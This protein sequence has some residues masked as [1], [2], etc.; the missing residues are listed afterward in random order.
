VIKL[1]RKHAWLAGLVVGTLVTV[2]GSPVCRAERMDLFTALR[3]GVIWAEFRGNGAASVLATIGRQPGGPTEV[4][5]PAGTIFKVAALDDNAWRQWGD[6][7]YGGGGFGGRSR[8]GGRGA[9]GRQGM[10]GMRSTTVALALTDVARVA[11]PAVCMDYGKREPTRDD[12][13]VALP[14][15][16]DR[17]ARLAA[18]L[19]ARPWS[20]PAVQLAVWAI[21]SNLSATAAER[22][23]R[24]VVPGDSPEIVAQRRE[25]VTTARTLAEAAGID[26]SAFRMFR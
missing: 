25:I 1:E 3:S 24:Q 12:L 17:L 5:V 22:Y 23:L 18:A 6:R 15:Q 11:L 20:Q 2:F 8:G 7:D 21:R 13:L 14:P 9:Q 4:V 10:Y 16:D 26:A 19:D